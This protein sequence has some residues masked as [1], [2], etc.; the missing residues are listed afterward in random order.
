MQRRIRFTK[1]LIDA[2]PPCPAEH[3]G[4]E[5][6]FTSEEAPPGLRLV[7]TKRGMKS[8]LFRY[9]M[10]RTSG[11]G[12]KRA[13]KIGVYPGIEPAEA[14]RLA[15][16]LRAQIAQGIDPQDAKQ[17]EEREITLDDFFRDEYWPNAKH[18]R[19][20]VDLESRW[21]L[22]LSKS[23]GHLRFKELKTA[24]I[25][26]FHDAKR[27]ELCPATANRLLALLKRV[28]SVGIMLERCDKNPCFGIRM[29]AEQN[30]RERTL[31]GD[32]LKRFMASLA[33]E[34]NRVAADFFLFALASAARKEEC[35]QATW[36]EMFINEGVWRLPASRA[37]SGKSRVIP[38][39]AIALQVLASR[40][41]ADHGDYVFPG[42]SGGHLVSPAKA[43]ARTLK[44]AGIK[45]LKIHDLRRSAA[46][47]LLNDGKTSMTQIGEMLGHARGS[48]LAATRYAFLRDDQLL[49]ASQRLA[50][51][52]S[53]AYPSGVRLPT[54]A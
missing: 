10:A 51:V 37:K 39:N 43:W 2:L 30:I 27:I 16:A 7:V 20:A 18:L 32:E 40:R 12:I 48:S 50:S 28:V 29:H 22:H 14:C 5:I 41:A 21:R 23:F 47:L 3:G 26:R 9:V 54:M 42:R 45:D 31:A 25:I 36:S 49:D 11:P 53:A 38:L 35:L 24:D 6:E 8:W 34:P 46:C 17:T 4:K 15:L 33:D 13:L 52:I 1:K 44:R 19:S